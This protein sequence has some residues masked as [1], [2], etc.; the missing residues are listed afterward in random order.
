MPQT[1]EAA[2]LLQSGSMFPARIGFRDGSGEEVFVGIKDAGFSVY[3]GDA[4]IYHF[5]LDGRWQRAFIGGVHY[6]KGL[7]STVRSVDRPREGGALALR[8]RTMDHAEASILDGDIRD[9]A[10]RVLS[11]L[12]VEVELTR[13]PPSARMIGPEELRELLGRAAAWDGAAWLAHRERYRSTYG[14]WPFLPPDCLNA[15]VLQATQGHAGGRAF[16]GAGAVPHR[17]R[18]PEEFEEHAR[19]VAGILGRRLPRSREVF[20][21]GADVLRLPVDVVL[22]TLKA[23]ATIFPAAVQSVEAGGPGTVHAFL[24]DFS[25]PLPSPDGWRRLRDAHLGRV[26]LGVESGS[27]AV[28]ADHGRPWENEALRATALDLKAAGIGVGVVALVGAGGRAMAEAHLESTAGLIGSLG[29]GPGDLVSL[30][31]SRAFTRSSGG[32]PPLSDEETAAQLSGLKRR[33]VAAPPSKGPRVV[34]YNPDN[35]RT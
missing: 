29:L 14:P 10:L 20:L 32:P 34:A 11:D 19:A 3:F 9:M 30:V 17:V 8:R 26:T 23:I 7:D 22:G 18:S 35:H 33:L 4:P 31:D 21:G 2:C 24:D 27:R 16:A 25:P 12:A 15:V 13:P 1:T 6:L 5:D 28:R